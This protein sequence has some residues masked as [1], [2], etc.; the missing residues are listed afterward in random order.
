MSVALVQCTNCNQPYPGDGIPFRCPTCGGIFD[1][2]RFPGFVNPA[3]HRYEP[4]IWRFRQSLGLPD[5][6]PVVSLGEGNTPLVWAQVFDRQVAF[7]CEHL[8]PSG[9]FK[10]RGAATLLSFLADRAVTQAIEDSSGNAGAAFAAYAA[11]AGIQARVYIPDS[12]SG[13]KRA[14]IAAY[15][16]QV[17]R[18]LGARSVVAEKAR[19]E[20]EAGIVYASHAYLPQVMPGYAT[21]A[22]ELMEQIGGAPGTVV[23]P[24]GQGNLL[25]SIGRG[26]HAM[27][28][29]GLIEKVPRLV[30]VQARACAPLWA[31]FEYGPAGLGWVT[32]GET[33]AEGVRVRQP[34]RGDAVFRQ[35][36]V[37]G[38]VFLAV[39]E[40]QIGL[41]RDQ[42]ARRGFYVEP[43]SALI[44][45][46]LDQI[47]ENTPQPL[48][49]IL[50][51][52]GLKYAG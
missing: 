25:L 19:K 23:V 16:A 38:G 48:V 27:Q 37:D 1:Y 14:Q 22:Y 41:G 9:S 42:L 35:V 34:M 24:V 50:T 44:W 30:G 15:G 2:A 13:P 7:K 45:D 8:N 43:T 46:A 49:A 39:D 3:A 47:G 51:G 29:A 40:D 52:N 4:G 6:A 20:A 17:V 28:A 11:R 31:L 21:I 10:D 33:L 18:I 32:E 12:A 36:T 26:F 5:D